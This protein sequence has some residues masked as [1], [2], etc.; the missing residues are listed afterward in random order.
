MRSSREDDLV[1]RRGLVMG[2]T[3]AEIMVLVLFALMLLIGFQAKQ[4]A[5]QQ[6]AQERLVAIAQHLGVEPQDIPDNF[7]RLVAAAELARE[8]E[9]D[10]K[11][12]TP[13]AEVLKD[14]KEMLALGKQATQ[15]LGKNRVGQSAKQAA[16]EFIKSAAAAFDIQG[17]KFGSSKMWISD[18]ASAQ[19]KDEGNGRVLPPCVTAPDGKPAYIFTARLFN[20][21]LQLED[22]DV[23]HVQALGEVSAMFEKI[24]RGQRISS[25]TFLE[26][27]ADVFEW[28]KA[29]NCRFYTWIEDATG[30]TEKRLYK[31]RLRTV[32]QHFYYFE[33]NESVEGRI[34]AR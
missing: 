6:G 15:A 26:Q 10:A 24:V 8:L 11:P 1:Y 20:E 19:K 7:D 30:P 33:P 9:R 28:S 4:N 18:A 34:A 32:G 3:M 16:E 2:L 27:T 14:A 25:A 29:T 23:S 5:E 22:R 31:Q 17:R 13:G 21:D 12:G